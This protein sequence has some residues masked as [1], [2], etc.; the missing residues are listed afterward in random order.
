MDSKRV[1]AL[2]VELETLLERKIPPALMFEY[3]T[4]GELA[5]FLAS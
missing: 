3:P 4:V 5:A 2:C 1:V